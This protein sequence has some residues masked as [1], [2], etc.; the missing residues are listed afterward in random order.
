MRISITII[1][2]FL[3]AVSA[4]GDVPA[5]IPE[6]IRGI[7]SYNDRD[8]AIDDFMSLS[9]SFLEYLEGQGYE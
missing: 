8:D 3:L 5:N 6:Y 4:P 1:A 7:A 9:V 2:S